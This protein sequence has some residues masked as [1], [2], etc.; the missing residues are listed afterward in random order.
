M[1][2]EPNS[3]P[4]KPDSGLVE[5]IVQRMINS[6]DEADA[7][8]AGVRVA[9]LRAQMP[10]ADVDT[11]VESLIRRKAVQAGMVGAATSGA[12]FIPGVGT[13]TAVVLG[14]AADMSVSLRLQTELVLEIAAA[15]GHEFSSDEWRNT[16]MVVTGVSVG[17]EQLFTETSKRL[18]RQATRRFAGRSFVKAIPVVGLIGSAAVNM[19]AT[20]VIGR[21]AEAY[22]ALGSDGV[23]STADILRAVTGV[24]ERELAAWLG[25]SLDAAGSL[26]ASGARSLGAGAAR[27]GASGASAVAKRLPGRRGSD[28]G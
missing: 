26:L 22:F 6:V 10:Q 20:Y 5:N 13:L 4:Q 9:D 14:T 19:L 25:E 24:N 2:Q 15:Y 12:S 3:L 18:T 21:R 11:L 16:V 1:T 28:G 17:A 7:A 23:Q 8:A 27:L